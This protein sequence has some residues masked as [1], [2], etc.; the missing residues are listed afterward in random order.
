MRVIFKL[1]F[2]LRGSFSQMV[3]A[4][5]D[6]SFSMDRSW[7]LLTNYICSMPDPCIPGTHG[8]VECESTSF[9]FAFWRLAFQPGIREQRLM[10]RCEATDRLIAIPPTQFAQYSPPFWWRKIKF[11]THFFQKVVNNHLGVGSLG[12]MFLPM[13]ARSFQNVEGEVFFLSLLPAL[14]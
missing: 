1:R 10:A 11:N 8:S 3:G 13:S 4:F 14:R 5:S 12:G 9:F 6:S 7:Y 2:C